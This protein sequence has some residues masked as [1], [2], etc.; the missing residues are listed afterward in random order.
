LSNEIVLR[1]MTWDHA[2]GYDP[3][4][5]TAQ[6]F[7]EANPGIRIIWEKRSLQAFADRPLSAMSEEYDLMVI[8]HPHVG[9]AAAHGMLVAFDSVGRDAELAQLAAESAGVSHA[10]YTFGGQQFALAIDAATPI[11]AYRPD[12]LAAPPTRW[13]EVIRLAEA[14]KVV[15]PIKPINAL[16][17]LYNQLASIGRPFGEDGIGA[18]PGDAVGVLEQM[19]AVARHVPEACF[20]MD[21]IDAYEWLAA[22]SSHSYVPYL[23]GYSNYSRPGFRLHHVKAANIPA[24]GEDGPVGS[25][26]GGTGIAVSAQSRHAD[27]ALAYAFW[28]ASAECQSGAFFAGGGQPGNIVAWRDPACNAAT[29]DFF[30]GT[31]ETLERSYLRPRHKGYMTFQAE[32][33]DIVHACLTGRTSPRECAIAINEAYDRSLPR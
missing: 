5:V 6:L 31:L 14:G 23:Y 10:S 22:R 29:D 17:S 28:I 1:G 26:I 13:S 27:I 25:P 12:L 18:D 20:D 2:R 30:S 24:L 33:G 15:W 19:L 3:M 11:A 8:D 16:M 21:P 4:V 7:A 32:G 9:E